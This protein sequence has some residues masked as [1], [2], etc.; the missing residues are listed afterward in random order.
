[1]V[2]VPKSTKLPN[3][4]EL[5]RHDIKMYD[6]ERHMQ[7]QEDESSYFIYYCTRG[8]EILGLMTLLPGELFFEPIYDNLRGL[9]SYKGKRKG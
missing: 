2:I 9:Y 3:M 1:M 5:T 8:G 4:R 6:L 7:K